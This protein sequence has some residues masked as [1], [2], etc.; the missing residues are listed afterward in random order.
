MKISYTR[1]SIDEA[2]KY[3]VETSP[4]LTDAEKKKLIEDAKKS[5]RV[6]NL[7]EIGVVILKIIGLFVAI[8]IMV[9]IS[10]GFNG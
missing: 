5:V 10:R 6:E 7:K 9:W 2:W 8:G 4:Y 1:Y 3:K